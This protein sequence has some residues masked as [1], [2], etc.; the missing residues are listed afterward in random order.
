MYLHAGGALFIEQFEETSCINAR[1]NQLGS[2]F[3]EPDKGRV[4]QLVALSVN[5]GSISGAQ[6]LQDSK[7][8]IKREQQV[9]TPPFPPCLHLFPLPLPHSQDVVGPTRKGCLNRLPLPN[10]LS[11][12]KVVRGFLLSRPAMTLCVLVFSR[13]QWAISQSL[14]SARHNNIGALF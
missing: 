14:P 9:L 5:T 13:A 8:V 3:M 11:G 7:E 1:G 6:L 2:F 12:R 10:C 4:N